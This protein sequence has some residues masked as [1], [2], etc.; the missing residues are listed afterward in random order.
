MR[1]VE[2]PLDHLCER[3]AVLIA[4]ATGDAG[5]L[6][7]QRPGFGFTLVTKLEDGQESEG[8]CT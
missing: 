5:D 8:N 6:V 1:D 4:D 7:D 2:I 3:Q